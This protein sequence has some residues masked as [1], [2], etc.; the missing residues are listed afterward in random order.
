[1]RREF[2]RTAAFERSWV[3]AGLNET[4]LRSL[5]NIIVGRPRCRRGDSRPEWLP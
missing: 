2:V 3:A 4:D 1:M 5:E